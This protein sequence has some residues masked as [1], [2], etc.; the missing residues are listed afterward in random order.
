MSDATSG[1][2]DN[3]RVVLRPRVQYP[4]HAILIFGALL[5]SSIGVGTTGALGLE[6][7]LFYGGLA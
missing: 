2:S 1:W 4:Y 3:D 6:P 5:P 7:P